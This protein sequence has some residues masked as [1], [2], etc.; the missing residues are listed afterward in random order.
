MLDF[1]KQKSHL[2]SPLT[3]RDAGPLH[4]LLWS[5]GCYHMTSEWAV[6]CLQQQCFQHPSGLWDNKG[7]VQPAGQVDCAEVRGRGVGK[8][9]Q[10]GPLQLQL[11][12]EGVQQ[13][14]GN[15]P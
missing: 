7:L 8:F 9:L 6:A 15:V 13:E 1:E 14:L 4:K 5:T 10:D 3:L 11:L 2:P 12:V